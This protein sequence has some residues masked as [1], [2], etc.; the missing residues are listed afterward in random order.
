MHVAYVA[1][2][3]AVRKMSVGVGSV[4]HAIRSGLGSIRSNVAGVDRSMD[5][6]RKRS[7]NIVVARKFEVSLGLIVVHVAR[8]AVAAAGWLSVEVKIAA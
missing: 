3:I 5:K 8:I 1:M 6:G 7:V 4:V 2:P